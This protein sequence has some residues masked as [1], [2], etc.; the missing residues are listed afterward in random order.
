MATAAA[1]ALGSIPCTAMF[2]QTSQTEPQWNPRTAVELTEAMHRMHTVW[3]S[4]N[5][6]ALKAVILGDDALV[7]FE[8]DPKTHE[9][10]RLASKGALD[11]FVDEIVSDQ[12]AT[13]ATFRL[14]TPVVNC[15]GLDNFGVCTEECVV[16][17]TM[18]N[19]VKEV[20][21]LWSTATAVKHQGEWKWIQ[22][23]MSNAAAPQVLK[24]G[25]PVAGRK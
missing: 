6:A 25:R 8:L 19:G 20:H 13:N 12:R 3:D 2:G 18:P 21:R 4:G 15:K 22:W 7:T 17:V 14:E 23:H 5:Q 10:I 24:N 1:I 16:H 11:K 9:P